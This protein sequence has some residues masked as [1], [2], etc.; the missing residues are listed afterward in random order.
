MELY[1]E[2][3]N[4]K[5]DE[6]LFRDVKF[7]ITGS[8][9]DWIIKLLIT[10]GGKQ[11]FHITD[12]MTHLITG[13]N[14]DKDEV[15]IVKDLYERPIVTHQWVT[16][17]AFKKD[18][19][20]I[21][22]G[23]KAT[24][25]KL[26][27]QDSR[28]IWG[29]LNFYGGKCTLD[30][31][32][33]CTHLIVGRPEGIKFNRAIEKPTIIVTPDWVVDSIAAGL[34][35]D[36]AEYH[37]RL[38]K[39]SPSP[40]P[41]ISYKKSQKTKTSQKVT[42]TLGIMDF[43]P[44]PEETF[45]TNKVEDV[46]KT[47]PSKL[48]DKNS[49]FDSLVFSDGEDD[50]ETERKSLLEQL[51]NSQPWKKSPTPPPSAI[52]PPLDDIKSVTSVFDQ[53]LIQSP[54]STTQANTD[55]Q[56]NNRQTSASVSVTSD[57][58]TEIIPSTSDTSVLSY[59]SKSLSTSN[60]SVAKVVS[61]SEAT[62]SST[63]ISSGLPVTT[64][65]SF[66]NSLR[67]TREVDISFISKHLSQVTSTT[68]TTQSHQTCGT[69]LAPLT[70][71]TS[72]FS[73]S[74]TSNPFT[75]IT[76]S[77]VQIKS[78]PKSLTQV[79]SSLSKSQSSSVLHSSLSSV[80]CAKPSITVSHGLLSH[81]QL[82]SESTGN[83]PSNH[84][85][86]VT[87]NSNI[88]LLSQESS[89]Q[90]SQSH[91][92]MSQSIVQ[93]QAT[94]VSQPQS[95]LKVLTQGPQ[96]ILQSQVQ[97][98][99]QH[100]PVSSLSQF[101]TLS[102]S[103]ISVSSQSAL[104]PLLF[105]QS[106]RTL[107]QMS[108]HHQT[109]LPVTQQSAQSFAQ[110]SM[111][112]LS[113]QDTHV[114]SRQPVQVSAQ[115]TASSQA[116]IRSSVQLV[117]QHSQILSQASQIPNQTITQHMQISQMPSHLSSQNTN[118]SPQVQSQTSQISLSHLQTQSSPQLQNQN[119]QLQNWASQP[120][121][122]S[123]NQLQ[124]KSLLS[125]QNQSQSQANM[126]NSLGEVTQLSAQTETPNI[127]LST[128]GNN[129]SHILQSM[130]Q[131]PSGSSASVSIASA[132]QTQILT[133]SGLSTTSQVVVSDSP[134]VVQQNIA[135]NQ[136]TMPVQLVRQNAISIIGNQ[137]SVHGPPNATV[138]SIGA[139]ASQISISGVK[140]NA[141]PLSQTQQSLSQGLSNSPGPLP[142]QQQVHSVAIPGAV[143]RLPSGVTQQQ[144]QMMSS[145]ERHKF[146]EQL[147]KK[148]LQEQHAQ[149]Q[150]R[151][152][153]RAGK[154]V[155]ALQYKGIP[156]GAVRY[157]SSIRAQV[158]Q[159]QTSQA[160]TIGAW[161][162]VT[163]AR[164]RAGNLSAN[165]GAGFIQDQTRMQTPASTPINWQQ[166]QPPTQQPAQSPQ[167]QQFISIQG[168][169]NRVAVAQPGWQQQQQQISAG[170]QPQ[171]QTL[172]PQ[173][174]QQVQLHAQQLRQ[175]FPH[176]TQQ[177]AQQLIQTIPAHLREI[178]SRDAAGRGIPGRPIPQGYS[179]QTVVSPGQ[180]SP[181]LIQSNQLSSHVS[182]LASPHGH[183]PVQRP[184]DGSSVLPHQ[185][186][187]GAGVAQNILNPQ[188]SKIKTAL[189]NLLTNRLSGSSHLHGVAPQGGQAPIEV[190]AHIVQQKPGE[191]ITGAGGEQVLVY[192]R[193][194]LA[195][196]NTNMTNNIVRSQVHGGS[197]SSVVL[198]SAYP[199]TSP[200]GQPGGQSPGIAQGSPHYPRPH[201]F[202]HDYNTMLPREL[203]MVGCVFYIADYY[204]DITTNTLNGWKRV[205]Q[206]HGGEVV[207]LYDSARVTHVLCKHQKSPVFQ[208][209]IRDNK[210]CITIYWVNDILIR[211]KMAPPW[212]AIHL[213]T[214]FDSK[215]Q[216]MKD[217]MVSVTGFEND[218][219][220]TIKL[221]LHLAGA[222]YTG[223]F[224]KH[225]NLLVCKK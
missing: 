192:Q 89:V 156:P 11:E 43:P 196:I 36:E 224:S 142:S 53:T 197:P 100:L 85:P 67:S 119:A 202:G 175:H 121:P 165:Q 20:Q 160:T 92:I 7:Y 87:S 104:Q 151:G 171:A 23:V 107:S 145:E 34:R 70:T 6:H 45:L 163:Q 9:P 55:S 40:L 113:Q 27:I 190:A 1:K 102:S 4:L 17:E 14:P 152:K 84:I 19:N 216:P 222:K 193:R 144:L 118:L 83:V 161:P 168:T 49:I 154:P 136:T 106:S 148:Q 172:L 21:F 149:Q 75:E 31:D 205:I 82:S 26:D 15:E 28:A 204:S 76:R 225:N 129:S 185:P 178:L 61:Q 125:V 206:Q 91:S 201:L 169:P 158:T 179:T 191:T 184:A 114:S 3:S 32:H 86:I 65:T 180:G 223:Y 130:S 187:Q 138:R 141:G 46:L 2:F 176:L 221:M 217:L 63:V 57:V 131:V 78:V 210:R 157:A 214:P 64:N 112:V 95:S 80:S 24:V 209:A 116:S 10:G 33:T 5:I 188:N 212:Q 52:L 199:R 127:N 194:T 115:Q 215:D 128:E 123:L 162:V 58:T 8:I 181:H 60:S 30:F 139:G 56:S 195:N 108:S 13:V 97:L 90:P 101:P 124:N 189:A 73:L 74:G 174:I 220:T 35:K 143:V 62:T 50:N 68:G 159:A 38:L 94:V 203:C 81:R 140:P 69:S 72:S 120:T 48:V 54:K 105:S 134:H 122:V 25:S 164:V 96:T 213:P 18:P 198:G 133:N 126:S 59:S 12:F 88:N 200:A 170:G 103:G 51:K 208:Q 29:L 183:S 207:N 79:Q 173:Q 99:S 47:S 109:S 66:P 41:Q 167:P 177:E 147:H 22:S 146:L 110:Q 155:T 117:S 44:E 16:V 186:I 150:Q 93:P 153:P 218:E 77:E 135:N 211:G 137:V 98:T 37:P 42:K 71:S 111:Q 219:R 182:P 166:Q 39:Q 132:Q